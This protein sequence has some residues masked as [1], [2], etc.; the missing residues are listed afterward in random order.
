MQ[1]E[2]E[3]YTEDFFKD[4]P[5]ITMLLIGVLLVICWVGYYYL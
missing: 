4:H 5:N 1:E 2:T 3:E